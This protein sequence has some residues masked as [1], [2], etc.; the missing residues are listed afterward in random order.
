MLQLLLQAAKN[1]GIQLISDKI[2]VPSCELVL[3]LVSLNL[4]GFVS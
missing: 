1:T 4:S 2:F 3:D